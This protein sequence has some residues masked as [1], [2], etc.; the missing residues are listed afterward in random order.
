[1]RRTPTVCIIKAQLPVSDMIRTP[2]VIIIKYQIPVIYLSRTPNSKHTKEPDTSQS[3]EKNSTS[4]FNK[5]QD[6]S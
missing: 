6:T 4:T 2:T 1:M 5:G 3:Y